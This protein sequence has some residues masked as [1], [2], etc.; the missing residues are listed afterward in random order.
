MGCVNSAPKGPPTLETDYD[1][2]PKK[3]GS[4]QYAEVYKATNK[5]TKMEVAVKKI[6]RAHSNEQNLRTEIDI[7]RQFGVHRNIVELYDVYETPEELQLVIELMKGGELFD[8]LV[9][10]GPYEEKDATKHMKAIGGALHFLHTN[11]VVHRD[12]KPENLLLTSKNPQEAVLKI[13]DFG[14]SKIVKEDEMM[15]TACGTWAYCAP[16]V[17]RCRRDRK[18]TGG[19]GSQCDMYSVGVILFVILAGYHPFDPEGRNSDRKMQDLI[20]KNQWDFNDPAW[21]EV[22]N[23][24]KELVK[25]LIEPD[26][27]KRLS[28]EQMLKHPWVRGSVLMGKLSNTIDKDVNKYQQRMRQ[29]FKGTQTAVFAAMSFKAA[30]QQRASKMADQL[31]KAAAAT[32]EADANGVENPMP[33]LAE[34][35]GDKV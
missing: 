18:G 16:E 23:S 12:L 10:N 5:K 21:A 2:V 33:D 15:K 28:A 25:K 30:G 27:E 34:D 4:G 7:L 6:D 32:K 17:L 29:K 1:V 3:L 11:N 8:A 22:S 35:N 13:G 19:Y 24:A 31:K 9:T 14:L 20:L 26:P